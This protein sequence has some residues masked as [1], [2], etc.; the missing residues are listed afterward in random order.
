[1]QKN[2]LA[3]SGHELIDVL[4]KLLQYCHQHQVTD[5]H[6]EPQSHNIR[7]RLRYQ[8]KLHIYHSISSSILIRI[9][10][11]FKLLAHLDITNSRSPQDGQFIWNDSQNHFELPCR[12][13]SCPTLYGEKIVIRLLNFK[14]LKFDW[15]NIG[16]Q[17]HQKQQLEFYLKL[18]NGLILINGPTGS[19]KTTS[20]YCILQHLNHEDINIVSIEDPIEIPHLGFTQIEIIPEIDFGISNTLKSVLRQDP[21]ILM[22]GEIRDSETAKLML[23]ASQT[24]HLVLSSIHAFHPLAVFQRLFHLGIHHHD[25]VDHLKLIISQQLIHQICQFCITGCDK[26]HE[27]PS[28]LHAQFEFLE[29]T[30]K[31]REY[32]LSCEHPMQIKM[33]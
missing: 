1:M 19:G 32:V 3:D 30:E 7:L 20:L 25:L 26:C 28:R 11:R 6:F 16:L 12:L 21:D 4:D 29:I 13:S 22:I 24:G 8:Q 31:L 27:Q 10:Q 17:Q 14:K 23:Q 2:Y 33:N 18:K 15:N 5:L 9:M